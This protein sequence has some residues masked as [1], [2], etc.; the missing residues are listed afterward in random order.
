MGSWHILEIFSSYEKAKECF[1]NM[2]DSD[3]DEKR[4]E[5]WEVK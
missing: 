5:C 4:I 2:M 1:D 3:D